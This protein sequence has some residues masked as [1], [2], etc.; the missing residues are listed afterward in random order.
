MSAKKDNNKNGTDAFNLSAHKEHEKKE[1]DR[2]KKTARAALITVI[3][4]AILAGAAMFLNSS[5]V[6]RNMTAVSIGD[7]KYTLT[8]YKYYFQNT[9]LQYYSTMSSMGDSSMLPDASKSLKSQ[10]YDPETGQTWYDFFEV[11]ALGQMKEDNR[12]YVEALAAGYELTDED[13]A[14]MESSID[15]V[16]QSGYMYGAADLDTYLKSMYGKGMNEQAYRKALERSFLIDSY[17][18]YLYNS[19]SYTDEE[20]ETYYDENSDMLD[21]FTYRY[22]HITAEDFDETDLSEEEIEAA[23]QAAI[24]AAV[25][26]GNTYIEGIA[27]EQDF[28][29]AARDYNAETNADDDATKR[30]YQGDMLGSIY[31]PWL[32]ESARQA[33]DMTAIASSNGCY[34]VM[35]LGRSDNHYPTVDVQTIVVTPEEI[36]PADYADEETSDAYDA[37]VADAEQVAKDTAQKIYD[38]WVEAG[39][40]QEKLTELTETYA[41]EISSADSALLEAVHQA[42]LS[43][44]VNTWLF[45]TDRAAGDYD[46]IATDDAGYYIVFYAG[47][48]EAYSTILADTKMRDKATQEWKEGLAVVEPKTTWLMRLA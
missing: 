36:D 39:A 6:R 22:F 34:V 4:V 1:D 46:M 2:A 43:E 23:E 40:T 8:D 18:Q 10:I 47:Q 35:F 31:G 9:Y 21:Q 5:F 19:Y 16:E 26:R 11:Y 15:S 24:D 33:G 28:I 37:A 25:E 12:I 27:D 32:R 20:I 29:D 3:V 44:P 48:N 42:Q 14:N 17:T 13:R 41:I 45:D 30:V 7:V 38:E